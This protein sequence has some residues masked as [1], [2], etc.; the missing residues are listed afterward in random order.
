[1]PDDKLTPACREA[2]AKNNRVVFA[3]MG[4]GAPHPTAIAGGDPAKAALLTD[5][6]VLPEANRVLS[7]CKTSDAS[8]RCSVLALDAVLK[9]DTVLQK[10]NTIL[11]GESILPSGGGTLPRGG[12]TLPRK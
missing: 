2:M 9:K 7:L 6:P 11:P 10:S 3:S 8:S 12:S 5:T 4:V 1:M